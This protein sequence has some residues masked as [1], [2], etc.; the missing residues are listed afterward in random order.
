MLHP[1]GVLFGATVLGSRELHSWFSHRAL[2]ENVRKGYFDNLADTEPDLRAILV[3]AF[4]E[5]D[6]EVVGSVPLFTARRPRLD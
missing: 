6:I 2:R 4:D 5:V 1:E 3:T